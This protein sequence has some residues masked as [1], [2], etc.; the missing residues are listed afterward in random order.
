MASPLGSEGG[1]D[2]RECL[3]EAGLAVETLF[4]Y[5][6][7]VERYQH[8]TVELHFIACRPC[9]PI[10]RP[11]KPYVWVRRD[12]LAKYEFPSGNRAILAELLNSTAKSR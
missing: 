8:D 9:E 1:G 7:T 2:T 6:L 12:E 11:G 5:S 10:G 3:E 4:E